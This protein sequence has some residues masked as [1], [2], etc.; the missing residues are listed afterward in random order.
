VEYIVCWLWRALVRCKRHGWLLGSLHVFAIKGFACSDVF[1]DRGLI[2]SF[3]V[4]V[5]D[6]RALQFPRPTP[7]E[8]GCNENMFGCH[9][10]LYVGGREGNGCRGRLTRIFSCT[11]LETRDKPQ[12]I[13]A[14]GLLSCLQYPVP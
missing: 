6:Q 4:P 11:N 1:P 9:G 2:A 13:V 14:Q 10:I 12:Q 5:I 3:G 8:H 7:P